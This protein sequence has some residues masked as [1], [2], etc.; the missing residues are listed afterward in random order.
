MGGFTGA[1][2]NTVT[3]S[4]GNMFAALFDVQGAKGGMNRNNATSTIVSQHPALAAPNQIRTLLDYTV[5]L[6]GPIVQNRVF[7]FGSM[8]RFAQDTDPTGPVTLLHE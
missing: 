6:G 5:Q 2:V 8:Q 7:F 1:V 3:K 4:G